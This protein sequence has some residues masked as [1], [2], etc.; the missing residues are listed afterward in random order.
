MIAKSQNPE[1]RN[2]SEIHCP[3]LAEEFSF[4]GR[5]MMLCAKFCLVAFH[6]RQR[7]NEV[8]W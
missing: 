3:L 1:G 6:V 5:V 7:G 8:K 4:E 2:V